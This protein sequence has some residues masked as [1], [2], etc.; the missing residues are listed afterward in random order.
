MTEPKRIDLR[1]MPM[2]PRH[3]L[4]F[5]TIFALAPGESAEITNDHD[6]SGLA[7]RLTEEHPGRFVWTW[8]EQGPVDWRFR[9]DRTDLVVAE[10]PAG[11]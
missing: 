2:D 5:G 10:A 7:A 6:P 9:L 11:G 8:L 1:G 3:E 4:L